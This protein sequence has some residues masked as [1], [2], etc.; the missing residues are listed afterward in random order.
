[1]KFLN[2][3]E[4][5]IESYDKVIDQ[6]HFLKDSDIYNSFT[7]YLR[8]KADFFIKYIQKFK[9][10]P[11]D[12]TTLS[13]LLNAF[14]IYN[15]INREFWIFIVLI[16]MSFY[17]DLVNRIY[18]DKYN[19]NTKFS[20]SYIIIGEW[21]KLISIA[22]TIY[23]LFYKNINWGILLY[24]LVLSLFNNFYF[25]VKKLLE[26]RL[27]E[28]KDSQ[29]N[30]WIWLIKKYDNDRLRYLLDKTNYFDEPS[31]ELYFILL[32]IFIYLT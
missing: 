32:I 1:M 9:L 10:K 19:L 15:L 24:L 5:F 16:S 8:K 28:T 26:E 7:L 2:F 12:I 14:A 30:L 17:C 23:I 3:I 13:I 25:S 27:S 6:K 22:G 4:K 29:I 20:V 11:N 21:I 18:S 31:T